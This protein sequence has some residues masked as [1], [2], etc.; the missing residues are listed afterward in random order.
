MFPPAVLSGGALRYGA[1]LE[2]EQGYFANFAAA[3]LH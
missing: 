1:Q 2:L 3:I